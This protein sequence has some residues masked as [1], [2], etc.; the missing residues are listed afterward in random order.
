MEE[1]DGRAAGFRKVR[2]ARGV[3]GSAPGLRPRPAQPRSS[4]LLSAQETVDRLLRLHFRD[5]RTRG[6]GAAAAAGGPGRGGPPPSVSAL[7]LQLTATR[8]C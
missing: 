8:S 3:G 2:R 6:T 7:S 5:G 1:R 4:A